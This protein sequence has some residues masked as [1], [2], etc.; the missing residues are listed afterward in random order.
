MFAERNAR[1]IRRDNSDDTTDLAA[2]AMDCLSA[3]TLAAF[4]P[5]PG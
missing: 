4:S 5:A 2:E 1:D 3:R